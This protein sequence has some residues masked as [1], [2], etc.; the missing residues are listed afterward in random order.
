MVSAKILDGTLYE[1]PKT[2]VAPVIDGK[3]DAIWKTLD[4]NFQNYYVNGTKV[5]DDF[6]DLMGWT[7]MMY[8]D[9]NLYILFYTQ[10][11]ALTTTAT[12]PWEKDAVEFYLD[13]DNSK[14]TAFDAKNDLQATIKYEYKTNPTWK[15]VG[16]TSTLDTTGAKYVIKTDT[17]ATSGYWV[18][19]LIPLKGAKMEAVAGTKF[20][21]EFQQD[22]NDD[23]KVRE[24]ISKW[25]LTTGDDSWQVPGHWGTAI[26][27]SRVA[28]PEAEILK[29]AKAPVID[30]TLDA[31]W[32]NASQITMNKFAN[33][34]E[35]AYD[36]HDYFYRLYLMYD[37]T[38]LYGFF[39]VWDDVLTTTATNPWEKDAVEIYVDADN[40][41]G[42]SFDGKNDVQATIKYEYKANPTWKNVGATSVFDTAGAKYRIATTTAG[43][44]VEFQMALKGLKIEPVAGTKIGLEAQIDDNDDGKV[45]RAIGKWW[46]EAGDYSWQVPGHWGTAK[47]G[48]LIPTDVQEAP[49]QIAENFQMAQNYPNPFNPVTTIAYTLKSGGKVRLAVYD[50]MG[51]EVALLV[52]GVQNA[53]THQ[54]KF[55]AEKLNSGIYFYKL[56]TADRVFTN[57]MT[58]MK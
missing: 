43:Y 34:T 52:D 32:T 27:S 54:I 53:G 6:A 40:S 10:D 18:E 15:N 8:D 29:T 17:S 46:L 58:L 51:K 41:K 11:E 49:A 7:K 30:G 47:L 19:V 1:V 12:N 42:A 48:A 38:N 25:W 21:V 20:G 13:A 31:I 2:T 33:G 4:A 24:S 22:D 26:L 39:D 37:D 5:P 44:A 50:L 55:S 35:F 14:G 3:Q 36:Y 9:K 56:Q 28:G 16:A 45:R 23:G 57:K